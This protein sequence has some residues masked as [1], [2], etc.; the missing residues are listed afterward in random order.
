MNWIYGKAAGF[1]GNSKEH[2]DYLRGVGDFFQIGRLSPS[3]ETICCVELFNYTKFY[4]FIHKLYPTEG[5]Q[6]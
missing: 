2:L 6:Y 1:C 4:R 3:Q 5:K